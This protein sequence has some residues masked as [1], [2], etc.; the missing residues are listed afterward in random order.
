[1][2][3]KLRLFGPSRFEIVLLIA[4]VAVSTSHVAYLT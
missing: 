4:A 1:M 3:R 2:V